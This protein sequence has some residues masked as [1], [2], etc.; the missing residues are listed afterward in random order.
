MHLPCKVPPAV[1]SL[2]VDQLARVDYTVANRVTDGVAEIV[3]FVYAHHLPHTLVAVA[4]HS[5]QWF[6]TLG[7]TL[8]AI[9]VWLADRIG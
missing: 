4:V 1:V 9:A 6:D 5:L 3:H 8:I 2:A 7:A